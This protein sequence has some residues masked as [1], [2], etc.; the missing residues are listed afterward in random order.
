MRLL[1]E[2]RQL[3]LC[4]GRAHHRAARRGE[5]QQCAAQETGPVLAAPVAVSGEDPRR[6]VG[7]LQRLRNPPVARVDDH[8]L[9]ARPRLAVRHRDLLEVLAGV[10]QQLPGEAAVAQRTGLRGP[11]VPR[12]P[13][14]V[15]P[16]AG[17]A[18]GVVHPAEHRPRTLQLAQRRVLFAEFFQGLAQVV[19]RPCLAA[20]VLV[21]LVQG[22]RLA[23]P[24]R[25]RA[26]VAGDQ[27]GAR[28]LRHRPRL[29]ALVLRPPVQRHR[30][31]QGLLRL[32]Y[33]APAQIHLA[34]LEVR[35]CLAVHALA[36]LVQL[37]CLAEHRQRLGEVRPVP[38]DRRQGMQRPG[39]VTVQVR[40]GLHG[41]GLAQLG[42]GLGQI[43]LLLEGDAQIAQ[44]AGGARRMLGLE[45][46]VDHGRQRGAGLVQLAQ[47]AGGDSRTPL[48]RAHQQAL[49]DRPGQLVQLAEAVEVAAQQ[50]VVGECAQQMRDRRLVD[51]LVGVCQRGGDE[52][53]LV[54]QPLQGRVQRG[55]AV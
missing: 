49:A 1:Y 52:A 46:Q 12:H 7:Q 9:Q 2:L 19:H 5:G 14:R 44:R 31:A 27:P 41:E 38:L 45:V 53:G 10:V 50:A 22:E 32:R 47:L 24:V 30:G 20:G 16:G 51:V 6:L 25:G 29:T 55:E 33:L 21:P 17:Q 23:Q 36:R 34:Q 11:Q 4:H 43:A 28:Q 37:Q 3:L 13:A 15:V 18:V 48:H 35:P 42:R 39:P 8:Q 54:V 40:A 26:R